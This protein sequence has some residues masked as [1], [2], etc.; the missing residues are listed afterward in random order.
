MVVTGTPYEIGI[1]SQVIDLE[2]EDISCEELTK[3]PYGLHGGTGGFVQNKVLV[4]GGYESENLFNK[5]WILN[6][7][8][9]IITMEYARYGTSSIIINDKVST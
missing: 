2:D 8:Q 7:E 6:A 9:T 3:S 1:H 4:C 5:C